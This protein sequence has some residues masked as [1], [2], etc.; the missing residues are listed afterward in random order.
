[1]KRLMLIISALFLCAAMPAAANPVITI[2]ADAGTNEFGETVEVSLSAEN[3]AVAMSVDLYVG[4]ILPGGDIWSTQY[5]G[6]SH[7]IEPWIPDIYVPAW[8]EM[9]RTQFWTLELPCEAPPIDESGE[10][11]FAALLT[12][13]GTFE[14]V[15]TAS[16]AGY[17]YEPGGSTEIEM[18]SIPGGSF[19]MGSPD[20]EVGRHA[21]EGPQRT[22]NIS[23]FSMLEAEVTERQWEEVMGWNDCYDSRGDNYPVEFV[24]WLDCVSFCNKLSEAVGLEQCYTLSN[25]TYNGVHIS[26]ADVTCDFEASGFRLPTEAEWEYACKA[27]TTTRFNKGDSEADLHLAAWYTANSDSLKQ[28]VRQKQANQF[29]LYDTHGNVWEWCWDYY[30]TDYYGT[31]PD[32]DDN[33]TGRTT[34]SDRIQRGGSCYDI[35]DFCRSAYRSYTGPNR[36]HRYV[37]FRVVRSD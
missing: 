18:I 16:L 23:S 14:Y 30:Y 27:G 1:M 15:S 26:T 31:R 24:S 22:V 29:G 25:I 21:N 33:P 8:F 9:G 3:D 12:Y 4:V 5:D 2:Y 11:Y 6:W 7:S 19:L 36:C 34:G 13:P 17:T 28:K 37:G 35:V 32:P 10:Y 20:D